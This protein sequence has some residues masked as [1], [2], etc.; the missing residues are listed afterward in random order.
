MMEARE[1]VA[2]SEREQALYEELCRTY[3]TLAAA[4]VDRGEAFDPEAVRREQARAEALIEE[5]RP[6]AAAVASHRLGSEPVAPVVQGIWR[7]TAALAAD[8]AKLNAAIARHANARR[9]LVR[10]R[11]DGLRAGRRGLAGYRSALAV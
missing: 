2:A 6:L 9:E 3:G 11:L 8:A 10:T 4:F 5:L 7:R 1:L